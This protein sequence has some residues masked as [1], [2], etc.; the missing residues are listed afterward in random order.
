MG[1]VLKEIFDFSRSKERDERKVVVKGD[2]VR[3]MFEFKHIHI[4]KSKIRNS[5][6]NYILEEGALVRWVHV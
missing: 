1:N 4:I 6:Y 2:A 3:C 5:L